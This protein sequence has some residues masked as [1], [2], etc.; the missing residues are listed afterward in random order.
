MRDFPQWQRRS[1]SSCVIRA[2][3]VALPF[4]QRYFDS[5]SRS[6]SE[7]PDSSTVLPLHPPLLH[8]TIEVSNAFAHGKHELLHIQLPTEHDRKHVV[9]IVGVLT[10]GGLHLIQLLVMVV[11]QCI[12]ALVQASERQTMGGQHQGVPGQG[13]A[14]GL[15]AAHEGGHRVRF[16]FRGPH[17]QIAGNGR[18]YLV[19]TDQQTI[20]L[21]GWSALHGIILNNKINNEKN[22]RV[23]LK[24]NG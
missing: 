5:G 12:D 24:V 1:I 20:A 15:E 14:Y 19:A 4:S 10:A 11:R 23:I 2:A 21:F 3:S 17:H 9:G 16:R 7:H 8:Q 13:I 22:Q 18:Q 6:A